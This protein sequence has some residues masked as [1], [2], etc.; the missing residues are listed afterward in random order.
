MSSADG[1][2]NIFKWE[3]GIPGKKGT[4]WEDGVYKVQIIFSDDYP[5]AC[6]LVQ[7]TPCIFHPNV[8]P[9]GKICLSIL[10]A[11]KDWRPN[12]TLKQIL[13]GI[14]DLLDNPNNDDAAQEEAF[15]IYKRSK[16]EYSKRVKLQAKK[17][18]PAE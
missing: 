3:A 16:T 10:N 9:S 13:C 18:A 2:S 17:Y 11:D 6:P 8:Y 15:R 7:F 4:D 1:S 12:I 5:T 14:Q